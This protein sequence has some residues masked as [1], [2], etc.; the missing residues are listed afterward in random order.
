MDNEI[1]GV[2]LDSA[3]S[4]RRADYMR[5][6]GTLMGWYELIIQKVKKRPGRTN[7]WAEMEAK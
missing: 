2:S 7:R 6:I 5:Q 3:G 4:S 1:W